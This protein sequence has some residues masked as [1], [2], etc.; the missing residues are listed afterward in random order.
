MPQGGIDLTPKLKPIG[1]RK[2]LKME[3]K[4]RPH[5]PRLKLEKFNNAF[6][7]KPSLDAQI[8]P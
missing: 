4:A 1:E 6:G 3:L 8:R 2:D 7:D 5:H